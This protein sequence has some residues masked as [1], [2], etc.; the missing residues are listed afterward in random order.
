MERKK[1]RKSRQLNL[2]Q[3][4][5]L[6]VKYWAID[7][8]VQ[9]SARAGR[10]AYTEKLAD[11][12]EQAAAEQKMQI[13]YGITE[14]KVGKFQSPDFPIKEKKNN[15]SK[16]GRHSIKL[17]C[18]FETVFNVKDPVNEVVITQA[19]NTSSQMQSCISEL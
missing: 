17:E 18:L 15:I 10:K 2:R 6:K 8:E 9:M 11:E 5:Q 16:R 3:K 7:K 12:A 1:T 4:V 19:M 13:L 14:A